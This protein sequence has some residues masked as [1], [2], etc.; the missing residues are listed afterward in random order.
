MKNVIPKHL[1]STPQSCARSASRSMKTT[2]HRRGVCRKVTANVNDAVSG[3][4]TDMHQNGSASFSRGRRELHQRGVYENRFRYVMSC[5]VWRA[6]ESRRAH[7]HHRGRQ[8]LQIAPVKAVDL[9]AGVSLSS[10]TCGEGD[11]PNSEIHSSSARL[12]QH[13]G[14]TPGARRGYKKVYYPDD[15]DLKKSKLNNDLL[16]R[17]EKQARLFFFASAEIIGAF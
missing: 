4:S 9:R 7:G 3:I 1:E 14:K 13:V 12:R 2:L 11:A 15:Y 10:R 5:G 17:A 16:S 8:T 6:D